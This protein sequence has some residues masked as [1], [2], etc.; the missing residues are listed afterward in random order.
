MSICVYSVFVLSC[1]GSGLTRR[2]DRAF[3]EAYPLSIR[4][5]FQNYKIQNGPKPD[6]LIRQGRGKRKRY[7]ITPDIEHVYNSYVL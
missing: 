3:K 4:F 7:S 6:S 1:A 2:A 5:K